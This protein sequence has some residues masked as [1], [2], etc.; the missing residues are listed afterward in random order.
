M[1]QLMIIRQVT[2]RRNQFE[3]LIKRNQ[4][5]VNQM[6]HPMMIFRHQMT[7]IHHRERAQPVEELVLLNFNEKLFEH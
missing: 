3:H 6:K 2:V 4:Q 7:R 1:I 5:I